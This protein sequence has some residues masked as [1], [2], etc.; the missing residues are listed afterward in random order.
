M[1]TLWY[2]IYIIFFR[3]SPKI[4]HGWRSFLLSIFGAKLGK[5]V[6]VYPSTKVWAPWNLVM[7]DFSCLAEEVDCYN[8][9]QVKIGRNSTVSQYSYI[10]TA[11][12]SYQ[13]FP[14]SLVIAAIEIGDHVWVAA[15]V[16][17]APG[18]MIGHHAVITARCTISKDIPDGVVVK[19][20]NSN[21]IIEKKI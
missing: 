16:F 3:T 10:C 17:I 18:V 2:C 13:A 9:A 14:M 12:R 19:N 20:S 7:E 8:V 1:R 6:H 4:F 21:I 15:D 5:G 11:S